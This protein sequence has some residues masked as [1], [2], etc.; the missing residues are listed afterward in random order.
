MTCVIG[1]TILRIIIVINR[2]LV[3]S[4]G[5][6]R[7]LQRD[8]AGVV[9]RWGFVAGWLVVGAVVAAV[10]VVAAGVGVS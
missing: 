10:A 2:L 3:L 8:F 9:I 6:R 7:Q 4:L 1:L 5:R